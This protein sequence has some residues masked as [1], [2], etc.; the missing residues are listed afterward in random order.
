MEISNTI[1]HN[2]LFFRFVQWRSHIASRQTV[3]DGKDVDA[4][5]DSCGSTDGYHPLFPG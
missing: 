1:L 2:T 4:G 3:A 5:D